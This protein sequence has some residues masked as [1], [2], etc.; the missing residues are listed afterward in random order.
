MDPIWKL[1]LDRINRIN[2]IVSGFFWKPEIK[3]ILIIL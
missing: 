3:K 2:R 1:F